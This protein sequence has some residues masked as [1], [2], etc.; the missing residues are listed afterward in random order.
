MEANCLGIAVTSR[1]GKP[2]IGDARRQHHFDPM[3]EPLAEGHAFVDDKCVFVEELLALTQ[4]LRDFTARSA[5]H[6]L[7]LAF[8]FDVAQVE[9]RFPSTVGASLDAALAAAAALAAHRSFSRLGAAR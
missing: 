6:R 4:L 8:A 3:R 5:I 7:V 9:P 1:L 2:A